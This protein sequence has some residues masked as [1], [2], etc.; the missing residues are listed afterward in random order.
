MFDINIE[1][2]YY[3]VQYIIILNDI[4]STLII[5]DKYT[6]LG[7]T[8]VRRDTQFVNPDKINNLYIIM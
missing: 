6:I 7:E 3:T 1:Y 5:S 2:L 4:S 8:W